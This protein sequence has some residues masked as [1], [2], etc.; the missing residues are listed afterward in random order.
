MKKS[1][2]TAALVLAGMGMPVYGQEAP[3]AGTSIKAADLPNPPVI[4]GDVND[5]PYHVIGQITAGVRKATLFSKAASQ[6]KI[7]RELWERGKKMG[8]DAVVHASFGDSHVSALSWGQTNATGVAIKFD[9]VS[10]A[11]K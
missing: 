1:T 8:A 9:D 6:D 2:L 7:F 11:S 10:S 4:A 5:R 3:G